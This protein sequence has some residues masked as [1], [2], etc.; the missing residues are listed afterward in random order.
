MRW[1][2]MS[3]VN[4][5]TGRHEDDLYATLTDK[6][7]VTLEQ[8]VEHL[9]EIVVEQPGVFPDSVRTPVKMATMVLEALVRANLVPANFEVS[10]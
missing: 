7:H 6:G 2:A 9:N 3:I 4:E 1:P 10:L 5:R 8:L